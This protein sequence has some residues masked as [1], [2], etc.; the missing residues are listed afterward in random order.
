[1]LEGVEQRSQAIAPYPERARFEATAARRIILERPMPYAALHAQG[2]V[3][4]FLDPGRF[5]L[6]VFFGLAPPAGQGLMARYSANG[7]GGVLAGLAALPPLQAAVLL[8][9]LAWNAL[10][11]AAFVWWVARADVPMPVRLGALALVAYFALV[12]GPVGAA[13]YRLAVYPLLL[14]AVP[15]AWA[16]LRARRARRAV[17]SPNPVAA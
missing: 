12:T 4:F 13:R 15:Y 9:L 1:V 17:Q 2:V 11:L 3:N 7:W 16:R 5:D 10:V 8:L 14:L 6:Q